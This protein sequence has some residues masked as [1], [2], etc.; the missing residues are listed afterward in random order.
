MDGPVDIMFVR[1]S[2]TVVAGSADPA[3]DVEESRAREADTLVWLEDGEERPF[4]PSQESRRPWLEESATW[5]E[6][7]RAARPADDGPEPPD[8]LV[9]I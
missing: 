8:T 7:S 1:G 4:A 6:G 2:T 3:P 9:W 5:G